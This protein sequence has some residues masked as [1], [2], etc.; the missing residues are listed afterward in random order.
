VALNSV[1]VDSEAGGLH[2]SDRI[3]PLG[4]CLAIQLHWHIETHPLPSGLH[5]HLT[6]A[7]P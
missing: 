3:H 1:Y 6:H 7:L 5:D 4:P 2:A